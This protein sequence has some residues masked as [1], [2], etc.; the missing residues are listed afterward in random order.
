MKDMA[1]FSDRRFDPSEVPQQDVERLQR[2]LESKVR[3]VL[4][5]GGGDTVELPQQINDLFLAILNSIE[6]REVVFLMHE[7]EAFTTQ[8]AANFLGVSRQFLARLLDAGNIPF[9]RVGTHRRVFF[10]DLL[11]YRQNRSKVRKEKLDEMTDIIV[12]A[13]VEERYVDLAREDEE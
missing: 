9:H 3:P 11:E 6:R 1:S 8:S 7:D 10:K 4:I 13:G 12:D 5:T 2:A